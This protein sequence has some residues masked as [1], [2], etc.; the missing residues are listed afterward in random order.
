MNHRRNLVAGI[1]CTVS[2]AFAAFSFAADSEE[3]LHLKNHFE[4]KVV[5]V[6]SAN[7]PTKTI[8]NPRVF[9]FMGRLTLTGDEI[10]ITGS[11]GNGKATYVETG[12]TVYVAWDDATLCTAKDATYFTDSGDATPSQSAK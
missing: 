7:V 4:G 2:L 5:F 12:A 9:A 3:S 6:S 10:I 8:V 1:A 11:D